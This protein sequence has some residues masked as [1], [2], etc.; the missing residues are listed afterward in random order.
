[1]RIRRRNHGCLRP[2]GVADTN[3]RFERSPQSCRTL[4][5]QRQGG[6]DGLRIDSG[7]KNGAAAITTTNNDNSTVRLST[8]ANTST[9]TNHDTKK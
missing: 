6:R 9:N 7:R 3:G 5:I 8:S 2:F 1:M 4:S